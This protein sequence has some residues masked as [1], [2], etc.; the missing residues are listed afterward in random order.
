MAL[1]SKVFF[2]SVIDRVTL[3]ID[4]PCLQNLNRHILTLPS[5]RPHHA[6]RSFRQ[7]LLEHN[8]ALSDVLLW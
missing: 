3:L 6:V 7:L 8:L 5:S 1:L 2:G 4:A